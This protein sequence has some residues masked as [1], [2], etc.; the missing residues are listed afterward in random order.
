MPRS[1]SYAWLLE[2]GVAQKNRYIDRVWL[3]CRLTGGV[4]VSGIVPLRFL[5]VPLPPP[6]AH[7]IRVTDGLPE[8][9]GGSRS[10]S[11]PYRPKKPLVRQQEGRGGR[12]G[13]AL[14]CNQGLRN[15]TTKTGLMPFMWL[16]HALFVLQHL[17]YNLPVTA[18][19][20]ITVISIIQSFVIFL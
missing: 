13:G 12:G 2:K 10:D 19:S 6:T 17:L 14:W 3:T 7:F 9:M 8:D 18:N 4:G 11:L 5:R 16:I 1:A 20:L 15:N